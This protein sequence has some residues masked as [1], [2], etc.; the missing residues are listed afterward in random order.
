MTTASA[1]V[2]VSIGITSSMIKSGT[3]I[4]EPDTA[5]GEVAWV[6]G[7]TY[8]LAA[9]HTSN[10]SVWECVLGHTGR[11][12][13]PENDAQYWLRSGPTHRAAPFDDY[14]NT[15]A[16][17]TGS[18]T[19]VM[20]PGF[21]NGLSLYGME[22]SGYSITIKDSPGGAVIQA[23]SGDLYEQAIGFYELLYAPLLQLTQ[24]SF[25]DIPLAPDA[26]V[27]ITITSSPG[28]P[29]A[30]GTIKAGDW[31]IF[32]GSGDFGG[33]QYGAEST[34]KSYTYR[35]Y[36]DDGTYKNVK[37]AGSRDVNCTVIIDA[38]QA[39]YADAILGQIAD[40]AVPFEACNLPNYAY[41]N[42][43]GFVSGTMRAATPRTTEINLQIKGNI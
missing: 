1:R 4:A 34:R 14:A 36:A 6:A 19:F 27:S 31:R 18:L 42:T 35:K 25:D 39:M 10:G 20:Q 21:L 24:L 2:M 16:R 17:A 29:V 15:K 40:V 9:E 41:I 22:G 32:M 3:T 38:E 37:R 13:L 7:G 30:I 5:A 12:A 8:V 33:A 28:Q 23:E 43:L 26:E 11:S